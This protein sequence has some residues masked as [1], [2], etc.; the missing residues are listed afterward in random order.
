MKFLISVKL[1][2]YI[3][4]VIDWLEFDETFEHLWNLSFDRSYYLIYY[5]L[6]ILPIG[7]SQF[8]FSS[9]F[10]TWMLL[11]VKCKYTKDQL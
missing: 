5:D 6:P 4:I 2:K 10:Q 8:L 7:V 11:I 1:N 9:H 3:I